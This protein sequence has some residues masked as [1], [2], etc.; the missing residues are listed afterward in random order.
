MH[1]VYRQVAHEL[2]GA[3]LAGQEQLRL[4]VTS[5]SMSPLLRPGDHVLVQVVSPDTLQ[6]G[7][8]LVTQRIDGYLTH[9]LVAVNELGWYTKG[10]RNRRA[11]APISAQLIT[12]LVVAVERRGYTRS[13]RTRPRILVARFQ[14]WLGWKEA[15][16]NSRPG[17]WLA[18][19][20]SRTI[21]VFVFI[22]GAVA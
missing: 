16:N 18:R 4:K 10:D 22:W 1:D 20:I 17:T 11:D 8:L 19:L 6:R 9:R 7:D 2:S 5:R 3:S 13:I 21:L 12:G 15:N 14:G